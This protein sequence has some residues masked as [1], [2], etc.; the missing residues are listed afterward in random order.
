[1]RAGILTVRMA[2]TTTHKVTTLHDGK[3]V[4]LVRRGTYEFATRRKASGIVGIVAVT[5]DGKVLLVEQYRPPVGKR[6]IELPAGLAGDEAGHEME[7]LAAAARR[8]LLEET[9]YEAKVMKPVA[10]GPPSAG[11]SDEVITMFVARGLKKTGKGDGDGSEDITLHEVHV[12]RVSAFLK[13][14]AREGCL[15]DLK[16]YGGLYFLQK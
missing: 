3:H 12:S 11:I 10:E 7:E 13:R 9:G 6:V 2:K 5:D 8:E 4:R 14:K 15:V 1:M 16:I